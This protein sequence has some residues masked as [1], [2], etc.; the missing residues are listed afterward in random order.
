MPELPEVEIVKQSL[1]KKIEH[2]KIKKVVVMN[3]NLRFKIPLNFEKFLKNKT[4]RKVT[5][6]SKYIILNFFDETFCLIHLG[7]S[8][9]IHLIEKNNFSRFS[10]TSFYNS[11]TLPEKHNHVEIH[12]QNLRVIYN[13]PRRF[14][15]FNRQNL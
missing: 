6:L 5:R 3:R 7:M 12:F 14:G 2:K 8:G 4:I 11:P 10:N 9:T 15:F 13:D 1:S